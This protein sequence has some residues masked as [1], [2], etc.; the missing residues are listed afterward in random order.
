MLT[1]LPK[2][3]FVKT[4]SYQYSDDTHTLFTFYAY[5]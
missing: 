4:N 1:F 5:Y 2:E 3:Q